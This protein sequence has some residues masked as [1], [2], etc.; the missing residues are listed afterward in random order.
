M[1]YRK[2]NIR[3]PCWVTIDFFTDSDRSP[4][5]CIN[6]TSADTP[7]LPSLYIVVLVDVELV[8]VVFSSIFSLYLYD[9]SLQLYV[10]DTW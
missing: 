8:R 2:V 3:S 10:D 9:D 6:Q 5:F 1:I 4:F 7:T